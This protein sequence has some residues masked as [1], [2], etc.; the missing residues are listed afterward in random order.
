MKKILP[1]VAVFA[2]WTMQGFAQ[3][4]QTAAF[5]AILLP[6]SEVPAGMG[7]AAARA[8]VLIHVVRNSAGQATAGSVDFAV[9]YSLPHATTVTGLE[10]DSGGAGVNGQPVVQTGLSPDNPLELPAGQGTIRQQSQT[11]SGAGLNLLGAVL[12][13]PGQFYL[14]LKTSARPNGLI[15]G[16][17]QVAFRTVLMTIL[18]PENEVPIVTNEP[19][20]TAVATV[21]VYATHDNAGAITSTEVVFDVEYKYGQQTSFTGLAIHAGGSGTNGP[22]VVSAGLTAGDPVLSDSSGMGDFRRDVE[23]N[24]SS[25][26]VQLAIAGL[27]TNPGAYYLNLDTPLN[28][29]GDIRAQLRSADQTVF[30]LAMLPSNVVPPVTGLNASATAAIAIDTLRGPGGAIQAAVVFF[31]VAYLF[32]G[33]TT[34]TDL[35]LDEGVAGQP[36]TPITFSGLSP[37]SPVV[38]P[39]GQ[40]TISR[41]SA[42]STLGGIA[43][44]ENLFPDPSTGYVSLATSTNPGGALRGQL[45]A[46]LSLAH[47]T[48]VISG[49]GDPTLTTIAPGGLAMVLGANLAPVTADLSGFSGDRIPSE[50]DG[51]QVLVAGLPAPLLRISP[52]AILFQ[53]PFETRPGP[54]PIVVITAAVLALGPPAPGA[55]PS[56]PPPF[57][58]T[59]APLAPALFFGPSGGTVTHLNGTPVTAASPAQPNEQVWVYGTGFGQTVSGPLLETAVPPQS[60]SGVAIAPVTATIGGKAAAVS[61]ALPTPG[62]LGL[63]QA[64]VTVPSGLAPGLQALMVTVGGVPSNT[65]NIAIGLG[66]APAMATAP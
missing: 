14:N 28:P 17:L 21:I 25:H 10:I 7:R 26:A 60:T 23:V 49:V 32:P 59:V 58:A 53:V 24:V 44:L 63:Y 20:A 47:V 36:G 31:D 33:F 8:T 41:F 57:M 40:G 12:Q 62:F 65:V 43:N 42:I 6:S 38:S 3:S 56:G 29:S 35:E 19:N 54:A 66:A 30:Q 4:V 61:N 37:Q 39:S 51:V 15:R 34:I 18:R 9:N 55:P 46:P 45:A 16:Q 64:L 11:I 1:A 50:L 27:F 52:T 22:S 2:L 13:N 48:G 5:R